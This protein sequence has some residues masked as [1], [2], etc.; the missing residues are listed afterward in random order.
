M[1]SYPRVKQ[2]EF[3][4]ERVIYVPAWQTG[5]LDLVAIDVYGD[6]RFYKVL[7]AANDIRMRGGYRVGIRPNEEAIASELERKGIPLDE[8]PDMVNQKILNSRPNNLDWDSY[9]NISYGYVSDASA[10]TQLL[11]PTFE[12]AD[13]Y[14]QRY[15][16]IELT[17][18]DES[19]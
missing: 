5:R 9:N 14:L 2:F 7:A 19:N 1:N 6:S 18:D 12:S 11:V 4:I 13:A 3:D 15:E 16:Y 10:D 17:S 8:I